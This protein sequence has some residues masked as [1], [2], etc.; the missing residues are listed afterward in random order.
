M[1]TCSYMELSGCAVGISVYRLTKLAGGI[2]WLVIALSYCAITDKA[3]R[4]C[5]QVVPVVWTV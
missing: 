2:V 5:G 1:P 4:S 3:L